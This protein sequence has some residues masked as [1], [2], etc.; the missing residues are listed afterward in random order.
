M[1]CQYLD[2]RH[3][4]SYVVCDGVQHELTDVCVHCL[5]EGARDEV[6]SESWGVY[7]PSVANTR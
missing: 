5:S 4:A 2:L 3:L 6:I 7:G 1:H